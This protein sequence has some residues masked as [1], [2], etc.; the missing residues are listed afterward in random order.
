MIRRVSPPELLGS[1]SVSSTS[2]RTSPEVTLTIPDASLA[3]GSV[4][5][6]AL[7]ATAPSAIR[8]ATTTADPPRVSFPGV[9]SGGP[10][11]VPFGGPASLGG[12]MSV[13]AWSLEMDFPESGLAID[14]A[15]A[16]PSGP[17]M[18]KAFCFNSWIAVTLTPFASRSAVGR[19]SLAFSD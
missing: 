13:G 18:S 1:R 16:A 14:R 8:P 10:A 12:P 6:C 17:V 3:A 4:V 5:T 2:S 11:S 19:P 7:T 9:S 15:I